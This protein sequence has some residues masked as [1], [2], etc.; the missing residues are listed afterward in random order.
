[1]NRSNFTVFE[2]LRVINKLSE[3]YKKI[4]DYLIEKHVK[5][6]V[7]IKTESIINLIES[8]EKV[9][10]EWLFKTIESLVDDNNICEIA[11][12]VLIYNELYNKKLTTGLFKSLF[13]EGLNV[14]ALD[15]KGRSFLYKAV[16]KMDKD[17]VELLIAKGAD[18]QLPG[19]NYENM[20]PPTP[21]ALALG[22][23][24]RLKGK[25]LV[26][27][28]EII[29]KLEGNIPGRDPQI[30]SA[31]SP[32]EALRK[33]EKS[34][35]DARIRNV[36]EAVALG[37][38]HA[39]EGESIA[40]ALSR[41]KHCDVDE[42]QEKAIEILREKL[43]F[44]KLTKKATDLQK[45][46]KNDVYK[47]YLT[48]LQKYR[49]Q[50]I[51]PN[52]SIRAGTP[53]V[54]EKE[55]VVEQAAFP[56]NFRE[57]ETVEAG[58]RLAVDKLDESAKR[59]G[60]VEKLNEQISKMKIF[61]DKFIEIP[62]EALN[63]ATFE[64]MEKI[65]GEARVLLE[66]LTSDDPSAIRL[67]KILAQLISFHEAYKVLT[68]LKDLGEFLKTVT[69]ERLDHRHEFGKHI[70]ILKNFEYFIKLGASRGE[71]A[72]EALTQDIRHQQVRWK[73]I[74]KNIFLSAKE[75]IPVLLKNRKITWISGSRSA[76][77]PIMLRLK[78]PALVP[79][80]Q[81]LKHNIVPLTGELGAGVSAR[82]VNKNALSGMDLTG[83]EVCMSYAK[84]N[85]FIF[86]PQKEI[87]F[88]RN[89]N[90][91]YGWQINRLKIA[92][93]RLLLMNQKT[94]DL[95]DLKNYIQDIILPQIPQLRKVENEQIVRSSANLIGQVFKG[96]SNEVTDL[97]L[98]I[99][100][101]VCVPRTD[102]GTTLGMITGYNS[103]TKVYTICVE[104]DGR[105]KSLDK[106][107]IKIIP[108]EDIRSL[109][110]QLPA[111]ADEDFS[112]IL[113][114]L[115]TEYD[116][117]SAVLKLFNTVKPLEFSEESLSLIKN[118]F[119]IIW[120]SCHL[121]PQSFFAGVPGEKIVLGEAVL[122][123]DIDVVFTDD[124][125][126]DILKKAVG[127]YGINV[128]SFNAA[129]Y[130]MGRQL[131]EM[132]LFKEKRISQKELIDSKIN[133]INVLRRGTCRV[134]MDLVAC[135]HQSW[136]A[137]HPLAAYILE[138][139]DDGHYYRRCIGYFEK[140]KKSQEDAKKLAEY[141]VRFLN[142][143]A[144]QK[145]KFII[146]NPVVSDFLKLDN[147]EMQEPAI[148]S[149]PNSVKEEA[150][151]K[152]PVIDPLDVLIEW[153]DLHLQTKEKA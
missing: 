124:V 153:M 141:T 80:G 123:K 101:V 38:K 142:D 60:Q 15:D 104:K 92:V 120:A 18:Q 32:V 3:N 45:L 42:L 139:K 63:Y 107:N 21:L 150:S 131:L 61:A 78:Q 7:P 152:I 50:A 33:L 44:R 95:A 85:G 145:L 77:I 62:F 48:A 90:P 65:E 5:S 137:S 128:L 70:P 127:K 26:L 87:Q 86:D 103:E 140:D 71:D 149:D 96:N 132:Q 41:D 6:N 22:K 2:A 64:E 116:Q 99:G 76:A 4:I 39:K 73:E 89:F 58:T 66:K 72:V 126:V 54:A 8:C 110:E 109:S 36:K 43:G 17:L 52:K 121:D 135:Q 83:L 93:L 74:R 143:I 40:E 30:L 91:T 56:N 29:N 28:K 75:S 97:P 136:S 134:A 16:D 11:H 19:A 115:Q 113:E 46:I 67:K 12:A 138:K 147:A 146:R 102:Q 35:D 51:S 112:N 49:E 10:H 119:P 144:G 25:K 79:T 118:S 55:G 59:E 1:M 111:I 114:A 125:H 14:N 20:G 148:D 31:A 24:R 47:D 37:Q 9:D 81:L 57:A 69:K 122:G 23:K 105:T 117:V 82:G 27:C 151:D 13:E 84:T 106:K 133:T 100:Q 88:I 34:P 108:Q 68:E 129:N 94:E 98:Q 130:I 53:L